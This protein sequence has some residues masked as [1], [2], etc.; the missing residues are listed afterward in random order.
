MKISVQWL[1]TWVDLPVDNATL[2]SQLTLAGLEIEAIEPVANPFSGIVAG[3]V[4][5]VAPHPAA[6]RLQVCQVEVGETEPLSIVCGASNVRVGMTAPCARIGAVLPDGTRIKRSKLRGVESHG[7][8]CS[9]TELG[10]STTASGLLE[11]EP[12]TPVGVD[13]RAFLGLD[14]VTLEVN[15]TPNRGDCLSVAGIARE[16]GV[17]NRAPVHG[18]AQEPVSATCEDV[19]PVQVMNPADCPR[20][21]GRVIRG[22]DRRCPTP[23]WMQERLRRSGLRSHGPLVDVTNYVMLALGQPMHAFDL[24]NLTGGIVVRRAV[25]GETLTLLDGTPLTLDDES[26]VIA[27]QT[28][29]LALAGIMGGEGSGIRE[30]TT[31]LFL[32]SAFFAPAAVVGRARRYGL[33]T[34]SSYRFERG[35]DPTLQRSAVEYATFLLCSIVGGTPG[36]ITEIVSPEYLPCHPQI[37]LRASRMERLLGMTIEPDRVVDILERLGMRVA[38]LEGGW[39]VTPPA[40]RFDVRLEADLIEELVRIRGYDQVPHTRPTI[41]T[42]MA[43]RPENTATPKGMAQFLVARDY[44]EVITYSFVDPALQ[45]LVDPDHAPLALS[46]PL[47]SDLAVMRTTLWQGL[48]QAARHNLHRQQNRVRLFEVGRV[49]LPTPATVQHTVQQKAHIAGL[50]LGAV[51]PEQWGTVHR[52]VD[53]FDVKGDLEALLAYQLGTRVVFQC[54]PHPH[55][56]LH[57]AQSAMLLRDGHPVGWL[58]TLHPVVQKGFEVDAPSVVVF[59][60]DVEALGCG[61]VSAF[62]PL[63]KFPAIRRDIAILVGQEVSVAALLQCVRQ[64]VGPLLRELLPFDVYVGKNRDQGK[65]SVAMG[66]TLQEPSRTLKDSEVDAVVAAVV[67]RLASDFGA[68]L[69][70]KSL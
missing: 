31:D 19:F 56:A 66:L 43:P 23:L 61:E 51:Y 33:Q 41:V 10:L 16:L 37:A 24:Q 2:A 62:H 55:P 17:L 52:S 50:A 7:M 15:I 21:V 63:S 28:S 12:N 35:V 11:L 46:N 53:F 57:P 49:F 20:Y 5:S 29:V 67:Q 65:K 45:S 54:V 26:L 68:A 22:V 6:D 39:E 18:P 38:S 32:E 42:A 47:S 60:L 13:L 8:L 59:A 64:T 44:Q 14:D 30:E 36:P 70:E 9:A 34:D 58:G 1:R 25:S 4:L 69:R 27:D 48:L 40:F 3:R